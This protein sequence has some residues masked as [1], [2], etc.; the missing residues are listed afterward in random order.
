MF[1][2]SKKLNVENKGVALPIRSAKMPESYKI[3]LASAV[4]TNFISVLTWVG[5]FAPRFYKMTHSGAGPEC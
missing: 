2:L 3:G 1:S 4:L 5:R